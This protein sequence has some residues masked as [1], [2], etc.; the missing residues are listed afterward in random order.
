MHA[1][2]SLNRGRRASPRGS[3]GDA[4]MPL[5]LFVPKPE[6]WERGGGK[7]FPPPCWSP[8]PPPPLVCP[9]CRSLRCFLSF[10]GVP[11]AF[12]WEL[13]PPETCGTRGL[14]TS[15]P[16]LPVQHCGHHP[17]Q[18]L[19]CPTGPGQV[20]KDQ[21]LNLVPLWQEDFG[22]CV[23]PGAVFSPLSIIDL[24]SCRLLSANELFPLSLE[25]IFVL[26]K[27]L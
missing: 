21:S 19:L 9:P 18:A 2:V 13:N 22:G 15:S 27:Q 8:S 10:P 16:G 11:E 23:P 3:A 14:P 5:R 17:T 26:F 25:V 20:N 4:F 1:R 6:L 24:M 7:S 12:I